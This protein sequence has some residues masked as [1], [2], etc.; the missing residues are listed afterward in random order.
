MT[1]KAKIGFIGLG[2]M[3]HS[4]C[5]RLIKE[6]LPLSIYSRT[7]SKAEDLIKE[8]AIWKESAKEVAESSDIVFTIV[9]FPK[10]VEE[11]YLGENGLLRGAKKNSI[12]I[13]MTT[14]K[15]SLEKRIHSAC[16]EKKILFLDAPVS[17]GDTGA[18]S[19]TLSIMVGG[20][21]EA[22]ERALPYFEILGKSI[23]YQGP[24]GSGQHTK[25]ANQIVIAGTMAGMS[26]A[27][28]YAKKAGLDL[29][30]MVATISKGAAGCWSLDN[31]A[32]RVLKG[33]FKPGFMVEHF[34]KDMTIAQEEGDLMGISLPSLSLTK[35][36]Y[37]ALSAKGRSKDGTQALYRLYEELSGEKL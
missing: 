20:D 2:V 37:K 14:T 34:V 5:S 29:E 8:G 16:Q 3:G 22:F 31:L 7:K 26:E 17:G 19:G 23:S 9:G 36:L 13:D 12:L 11:T 32:P 35:E 4:M 1:E 15:P 10:D 28:I 30:K 24:A 6:N 18:R 27:L 33:D 21:K 25:M